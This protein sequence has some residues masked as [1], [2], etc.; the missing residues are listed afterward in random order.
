MHKRW[1]IWIDIEGFSKLWS[2]GDVGLHALN[3]LMLG[4]YRI[5]SHVY[6][7]EGSR[8]F[9]HQFG[10]GFIIVSDF[11][12]E[13]LDR[14]ASIAIALMRFVTH[15]GC[16]A[17][18]AIAEGEFADI[19]GCHPREIRNARDDWGVRLGNGLMT[20]NDVMGTAL[21]NTNKLDASNACRGSLLTIEALSRNRLSDSIILRP[22]SNNPELQVIDWIHSSTDELR[23]IFLSFP[24]A[25][26][27]PGIIATTIE[28]YCEST[29]PPLEWYANTRLFNGLIG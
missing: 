13:S 23:R 27:S 29:A 16:F 25:E 3:K 12:E 6:P 1:A 9:A 28:K 26:R 22:I 15:S 2:V 21:V 14:C 8:L 7:E 10:D 18:A 5:G 20:L 24:D 4:I 11:A 17:R 19:A